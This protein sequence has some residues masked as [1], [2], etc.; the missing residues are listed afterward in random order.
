MLYYN[1]YYDNARAIINN[2]FTSVP[3]HGELY[4]MIDGKCVIGK[5]NNRYQIASLHDYDVYKES[6]TLI[7]RLVTK[8]TAIEMLAQYDSRK[9]RYTRFAD[10]KKLVIR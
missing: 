2:L 9:E 5:V 4:I 3:R 10:C 8:D 7:C 1:H 6:G